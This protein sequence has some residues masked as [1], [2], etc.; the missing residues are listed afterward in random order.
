M[1]SASM[2]TVHDFMTPIM[3]TQPSGHRHPPTDRPISTSL[4]HAYATV[5]R[6][7]MH[8]VCHDIPPCPHGDIGTPSHLPYPQVSWVILQIRHRLYVPPIGTSGYG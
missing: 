3:P 7:Q 1:T 6:A 8:T 4:K 5:A 2:M